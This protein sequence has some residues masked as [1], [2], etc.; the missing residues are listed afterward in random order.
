[1][2]RRAWSAAATIRAR[3][4]ASADR[5]SCSEPAMVLKLRSNTPISPVP[6]SGRRAPS[7]PSASRPAIAAADRT[8][9]TTDRRH[10][11]TAG[12]RAGET[13]ALYRQALLGSHEAIELGAD[14]VDAA[15][16]LGDH[17]LGAGGGEVPTRGRD[18]RNRVIPDVRVNVQ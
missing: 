17:T 1:M 12:G 14:R 9:Q 8:G 11:R 18:Q 13:L 2:R 7:S 10:V 16:A 4:A 5:L 15:H 3:D 6:V